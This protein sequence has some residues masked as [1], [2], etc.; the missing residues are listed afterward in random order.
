[1]TGPGATVSVDVAVLSA[2]REDH[3]CPVI[4]A[5][6]AWLLVLQRDA[7][8]VRMLVLHRFLSCVC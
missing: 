7:W 5:C 4:A 3:T 1:M 8:V 2:H 6:A